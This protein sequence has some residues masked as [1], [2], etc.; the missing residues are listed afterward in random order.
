MTIDRSRAPLRA[1]ALA[2]LFFAPWAHAQLTDQT[3]TPN[4]EHAG[5]L[6]SLP[7]EIG[8]GVGDLVTPDSSTFI[9]ARD[10]AR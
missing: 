5:I 4:L 10:P 9:I 7:E 3:Q 2:T 6:K 8:A 1:L